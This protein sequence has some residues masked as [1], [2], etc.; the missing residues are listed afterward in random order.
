MPETKI[1]KN[2]FNCNLFNCW[3]TK[4]GKI[5]LKPLLWSW[6]NLLKNPYLWV[7]GQIFLKIHGKISEKICFIC[8]IV[9]GKYLKKKKLHEIHVNET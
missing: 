3:S 1:Q 6:R 9:L 8:H 7:R 4:P 2:L 5:F